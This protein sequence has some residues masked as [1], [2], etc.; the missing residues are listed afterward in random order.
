MLPFLGAHISPESVTPI[1]L[2]LCQV[3]LSGTKT[4]ECIGLW[5]STVGDLIW[6]AQTLLRLLLSHMMDEQEGFFFRMQRTLI[7]GPEHFCRRCPWGRQC[8]PSQI[9]V[10]LT[11]KQAEVTI[12]LPSCDEI[13]LAS[14]RADFTGRQRQ[15]LWALQCYTCIYTQRTLFTKQWKTNS[16]WLWSV[17]I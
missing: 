12:T 11:R 3:P 16:N 4:T 14:S 8:S 9:A 5:C 1:W 2:Q 7:F 6:E 13:V 15:R 10:Q 17:T